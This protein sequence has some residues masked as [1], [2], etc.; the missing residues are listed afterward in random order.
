MGFHK[1][2]WTQVRLTWTSGSTPHMRDIGSHKIQLRWSE[3]SEY[4]PCCKFGEYIRHI[5]YPFPA[6]IPTQSL[7]GLCWPH[8]L[9]AGVAHRL[10]IINCCDTV[11]LLYGT[12]IRR[13]NPEWRN[14][15]SYQ[16]VVRYECNQATG[17]G[18]G[19]YY[20]YAAVGAMRP[21]GGDHPYS[22]I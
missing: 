1:L 10:V 18:V 22:E 21:D 8:Q 19:S 9:L 5:R 2:Q 17:R 12:T 7:A 13:V 3:Y 20:D 6:N 15:T 16:Q 11:R 4:L 14:P